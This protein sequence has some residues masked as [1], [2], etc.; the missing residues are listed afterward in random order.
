MNTFDEDLSLTSRE[1]SVYLGRVTG[2][3]GINGIPNGGYLMALLAN[4]MQL[5]SE[6]KMP[7]VV[8]ATYYHRCLIGDALITAE[9]IACSKRFDRWHATLAQE[10]RERIRAMGT[11]MNPR[12]GNA[13][14]QYEKPEPEVASRQDCIPLP[15]FP[16][17]TLMDRLDI[18]LDPGCAGWLSGGRSEKSE[19][20][21]WVKFREDRP[22]DPLSVLLFADCFPPPI[23]ASHGTVAW[24]PTIEFSVN[25][26]N[27]P[28]T[29]WVK[30]AFH[31]SF[32][33]QDILEADGEVW[34]ENGELVAI[35]R[36]IA[37]FRP[38]LP[39]SG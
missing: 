17:F 4:A 36:Q 3:W 27:I 23:M 11:F 2:N 5:Q 14:K 6:K 37:Q 18:R 20:K 13:E 38:G 35:S 1:P 29:K 32:L 19:M 28:S 21:G 15:A 30:C 7:L 10:G 8:T 12:D 16:N 25:V 31:T 26:R 39:T 9:N 22:F 33:D 24:V 34:D